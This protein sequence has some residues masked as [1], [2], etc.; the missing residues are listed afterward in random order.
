MERTALLTLLP[1]FSLAQARKLRARA[2]HGE[3]WARVSVQ[4]LRKRL[5]DELQELDEALENLEEGA[6]DTLDVLFETA[7]C[8][9]FLMFIAAAAGCWTNEPDYHT[10]ASHS[11]EGV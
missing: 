6:G 3:G 4:E 2:H 1:A 5:Q 9:N 10:V 8:A 11:S 7:D